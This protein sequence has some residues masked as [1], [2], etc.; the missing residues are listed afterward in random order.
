MAITCCPF[1][2]C[3]VS[4]AKLPGGSSEIPCCQSA[5]FPASAIGALRSNGWKFA[6]IRAVS[7]GRGHSVGRIGR[8]IAENSLFFSL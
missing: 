5:K 3:L 7:A 4:V 6:D 2:N 8:A 1:G